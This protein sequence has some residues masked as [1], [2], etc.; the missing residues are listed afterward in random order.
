MKLEHLVA[1]YGDIIDRTWD[2]Q[3]TED[4]YQ[5]AEISFEGETHPGDKIAEISFKG[6]TCNRASIRFRIIGIFSTSRAVRKYIITKVRLIHQ[7]V[8]DIL[9][10]L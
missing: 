8:L 4:G 2:L 6:D 7:Q 3:E 10:A 5:I 1:K 9:E